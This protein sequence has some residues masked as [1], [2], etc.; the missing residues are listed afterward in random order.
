MKE[1]VVLVLLG[2]SGCGKTRAIFNLASVLGKTRPAP[3][4]K[5]SLEEVLNS[6]CRILSCCLVLIQNYN[7]THL[8]G[9]TEIGQQRICVHD[10]DSTLWC[11]ACDQYQKKLVSSFWG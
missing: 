4:Q 1:S 3:F 8:D 2:V 6:C 7:F 10:K 11:C 9:Q 5:V